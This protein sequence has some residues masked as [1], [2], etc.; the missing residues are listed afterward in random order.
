MVI[1]YQLGRR[2][3]TT[4]KGKKSRIPSDQRMS[5]V[6]RFPPGDQRMCELTWIDLALSAFGPLKELFDKRDMGRMYNVMME[7]ELRLHG[8]LSSVFLLPG[9]SNHP[10]GAIELPHDQDTDDNDE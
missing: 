4:I 5:L 10:I 2:I 7:K 1:V 3:R 6:K 8:E 9:G